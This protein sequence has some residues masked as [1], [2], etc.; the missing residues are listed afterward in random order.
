MCSARNGGK[1]SNVAIHEFPTGESVRHKAA[2]RIVGNCRLCCCAKRLES[3]EPRE[4]RA[5][6][7]LL[8]VLLDYS[9]PEILKISSKEPSKL[10]N[11]K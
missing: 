3:A 4:C 9:N 7:P 6:Q 8:D 5:V 2:A 10:D 11:N 1:I